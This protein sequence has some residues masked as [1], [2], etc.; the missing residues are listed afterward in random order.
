MK[1]LSFVSPQSYQ[2][3]VNGG[4]TFSLAAKRQGKVK[5]FKTRSAS[6]THHQRWVQMELLLAK[7]V[8]AGFVID[9]DWEATL[10]SFITLYESNSD[11]L[12]IKQ[13]LPA[14]GEPLDE[15]ATLNAIANLGYYCRTY[16]P[17]NGPIDDRL[18]PALWISTKAKNYFILGRNDS[19][20]LKVFDI[21]KRQ[22][23]VI[24]DDEVNSGK[25]WLF[26]VYE[27]Q[28]QATSKFRRNAS[29]LS[30][31]RALLQR[32]KPIYIQLF[33]AGFIL[34]L[35]ALAAPLFIMVVY[36]KVV[37]TGAIETLP[38]LAFGAALAILL[39]W[40]LREVRS[41]GLSWLAGRLD[42]IVSN[43]IF[44]HLLGLSPALI[45]KA[46][47]ASQIARIKTFESIRDFFCG[48]AFLSFLELPFV[49]IA[50]TAV[51]VVAG[52][53]AWVPVAMTL[54]FLALFK[55]MHRK[56]KVAIR[57]A[58]KATSARQ[59]FVL[60]T[61]EKREE[62]RICGLHEKWQQ[63]FRHLSG[64]EAMSHFRLNWQGQISETFAHGLTLIAVVATLGIGVKLIWAGEISSGALVASMILIWKILTP[65]YSLCTMIARFEQLRN[66]IDQINDLMDIKSEAEE[67]KSFSRLP[68]ISGG[69][70]FHHVGF[71]YSAESDEVFKNL[72]FTV[73][74]GDLVVITGDN[75]SG[76]A[77]ILKLIQSM[78]LATS[79]AIRIDGFD[80][81]QLNTLDLRARIAYV[82]KNPYFFEGTIRENLSFANIT[83][84]ET[85]MINALKMS[86]A[87]DE[88]YSLPKQLDTV[89]GNQGG[90]KICR[91]LALRI[92]LARGYLHP[93]KILLID[94]LP[95][96]LLNSRTGELLRA[97]LDK[98][99]GHRTVIICTYRH[100]YMKLSNIIINLKGLA[101]PLVRTRKIDTDKALNF[102]KKSQ[103][104]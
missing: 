79:G 102:I 36:D 27:E 89:I 20:N 82:P 8:E 30:W 104:A 41:R 17:S 81:R 24:N 31:F 103:V 84:T 7:L 65:F 80:I 99:K 78:H 44:S 3:K 68:V 40:K 58:A 45:E 56:I 5:Q 67:A 28:R 55:I 93:S 97:Y 15:N 19:N 1:T 62:I 48:S 90:M 43:R 32:F 26:S 75:G 63:K 42:N 71:R 35:I 12:K 96:S 18:W 60:E 61:F 98:Q 14:K 70:S 22:I 49:I 73:E 9:Q 34:N 37:G 92:S 38:M 53:L 33:V 87:W 76:K 101:D 57:L 83:A 95:S 85:Q 16:K 66:S 29:N 4:F 46:S 25:I 59:Q 47:V 51:S 21:S 6:E 86:D 13:A 54:A 10:C 52:S 69:L 39:E 77:S 2:A 50:I 91:N 94:E 88:I 64:R 72:S 74:P 23:T 11:L 100:D